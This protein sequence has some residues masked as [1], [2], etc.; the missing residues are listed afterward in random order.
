MRWRRP[1][2][3]APP[4]QHFL[5]GQNIRGHKM[6]WI[7][8]SRSVLVGSSPDSSGQDDGPW[9][10]RQGT[11][12]RWSG[13]VTGKCSAITSRV[14]RPSRYPSSCSQAAERISGLDFYEETRML[15]SV[16]RERD[17]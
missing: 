4:A 15:K 8:G 2:A 13:S 1:T 5:V 16:L 14:S 9:K 6:E 12:K 11:G 10:R 17:P 3:L 7:L